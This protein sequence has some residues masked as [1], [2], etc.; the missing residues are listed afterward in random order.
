MSKKI[1]DYFKIEPKL[2]TKC[3]LNQEDPRSLP[4]IKNEKEERFDIDLDEIEK[5]NSQT[6][7]KDIKKEILKIKSDQKS[8]N[9]KEELT[10]VQCK[11]CN[12]KLSQN[13]ITDHVNRLH[14]E[15]IKISCDICNRK[16]LNTKSLMKHMEGLH[17]KEF[18]NVNEKFECDF[19]GKSFK[20]K[21]CITLHMKVHRLKI[22]CEFC[23]VE[24]NERS[25]NGHIRT[26]HENFRKFQ[27][28]M[29]PK[30]FK[31]QKH[32]DLHIR[33]HDKK[34]SCKYCSGLY[35]SKQRLNDHIKH[36]HE[37]TMKFKCEICDKK[38]KQK[39]N[40]KSH[41]KTHDKNRLM[42][43]KCQKC[44]FATDNNT[45]LKRHYKMHERVEKKVA[46]MI[47]PFK[48][49]KCPTFC[50]SKKSLSHHMLTVH[51]K[52]LVQ[53]DLCGKYSK[54][55]KNLKKHILLHFKTR[56]I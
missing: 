2:F 10:Q 22:K 6:I 13:Y 11:F 41:Q 51:P 23:E 31:I 45:S 33:V 21:Q 44:D 27:C 32:L 46:V 34:F 30:S 16:F 24:L 28:K 26:V 12:K 15:K 29:C 36:I 8:L 3:D 55:K 1:S 14:S 25:M 40:L 4:Q 20:N 48:C 17:G 42:L 38:F 37:Y 19:D 47:N 35:P 54:V 53:C 7:L 18:F 52:H 50:K 43:L 56:K 5:S 49:Q 39:Q 9:I